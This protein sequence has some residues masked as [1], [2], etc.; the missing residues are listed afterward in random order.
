MAL[1]R[2]RLVRWYCVNTH[3]C[4]EILVQKQ[5]KAKGFLTEHFEFEKKGKLRPLF[6]G[7]L[8]VSFNV[9]NDPWR[10][11]WR[12]PGVKRLFSDDPQ[13]PTAVPGQALEAIRQELRNIGILPP[14]PIVSIDTGDEI[15]FLKGTF[16]QF[17]GICELRDNDRVE[18]L[19]TIFGR[20]SRVEVPISDVA[21]VA[22]AKAA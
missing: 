14:S 8:F 10:L 13:R 2:K 9:E 6:P 19:L 16:R 20:P 18:V 5:I 7:Y 22:K 12:V 4:Q 15:Q 3:P 21:L 17:H 1:Q 11:L